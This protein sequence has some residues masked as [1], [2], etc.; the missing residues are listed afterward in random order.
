MHKRK[1]QQ[2]FLSSYGEFLDLDP[3]LSPVQEK[4]ALAVLNC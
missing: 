3:R 4:A 2:I 1:I